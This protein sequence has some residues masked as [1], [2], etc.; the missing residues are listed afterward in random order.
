M[1]NTNKPQWLIDAENEIQNF[2]DSKYGKMTDGQIGLSLGGQYGGSKSKGKKQSKEA[3]NNNRLSQTGKKLSEEHKLKISK[4]NKGKIRSEESKEK[5]SKN[6]K[7]NKSRLGQTNS[8]KHRDKCSAALKGIPCSE[9]QKIK[10]SLVSKGIPKPKVKC[11]ECGKLYGGNGN[12]KQHL[13]FSH[14]IIL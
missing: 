12:L 13:K 4:S 9:E 3:I 2:A 8:K 6:S 11:P 1:E 5:N 10:L 14:N 7:G